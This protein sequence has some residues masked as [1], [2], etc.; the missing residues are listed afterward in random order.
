M[1]KSENATD[2]KIRHLVCYLS[3]LVKYY[4]PSWTLRSAYQSLS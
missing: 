2:G 1:I 3:G 4:N